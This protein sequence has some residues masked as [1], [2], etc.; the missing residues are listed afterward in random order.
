MPSPL[1]H[2]ALHELSVSASTQGALSTVS[3]V[4]AKPACRDDVGGARRATRTKRL[5]MFRRALKQSFAI[6]R[7]RIAQPHPHRDSAVKAL[8]ALPLESRCT[9][10]DQ[11][12]FHE[13]SKNVG[14]PYHP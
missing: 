10:P 4:V 2:S 7:C 6:G 14:A 11:F 8:A 5:D 13:N 3:S 9:K 1:G 12:V